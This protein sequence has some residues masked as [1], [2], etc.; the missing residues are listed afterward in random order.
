MDICFSLDNN[1]SMQL[2]VCIASILKN[3]N[4]DEKFNF[5]VLDAGISSLNKKKISML[6]KIKDFNITYVN[7]DE[8]KFRNC[9]FPQTEIHRNKLIPMAS[10]YRLVLPS[11]FPNLDKML[12]LDVDTIVLNNL[13]VLYNTDITD[14][15]AAMALDAE[16]KDNAPRLH[17]DKY[18]NAGI[19]LLNLKKLREDN[20]EQKFFD[21]IDNNRESIVYHDQDVLNSVLRRKI[22][23]VNG[24]YN[25]QIN[26]FD[27]VIQEKFLEILP[28][29]NII[30]YAGRIR[31]WDKGFV[32]PC[33][34]E[35]FKYLA[36]TPWAHKIVDF[37]LYKPT[38][39]VH[40]IIE[41]KLRE[42]YKFE[43]EKIYE[44]AGR[45]ISELYTFNYEQIDKIVSKHVALLY[46]EM[47]KKTDEI[48]GTKISELYNFSYEK[49]DKIISEK[50]SD[51]YKFE[52]E[53]IDEIS[54]R[55]IAEL[56][57]F[58]YEQIDK[59]VS[60]H[61]ALFYDEMYRKIEDL[62]HDKVD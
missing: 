37:A 38:M 58:N 10:Y 50:L 33:F 61:V 45:K 40:E 14:Y 54:S 16:R 56:Y 48:I 9:P 52:Y 55:K 44:I 28:Y 42:L 13:D 26:K 4:I 32:F 20:I 22:K 11:L 34:F 17:T 49:T 31:P 18:F 35:F 57:N 36:F 39:Q 59:I 51:L 23:I 46:D 15:Y 3:I 27:V 6:K 7:V 12:Y 8:D 24:M 19:L 53:K 2:G 43:Y 29:I 5:Y 1:Y 60:K 62:T 47:Y 41:E 30:H 25:V 21:Y